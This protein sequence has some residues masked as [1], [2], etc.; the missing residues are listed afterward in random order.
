[1]FDGIKKAIGPTV[2]KTAPLKSS[3]GKT[4]VDRNDQIVRW[5][6][7]Y[8]ELYSRETVVTEAA[9]SARNGRT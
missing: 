1:M 8:S 7:H 3:T 9:L 6:E 4:M 2:K 5:V